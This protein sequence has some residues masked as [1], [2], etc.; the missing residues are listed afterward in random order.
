LFHGVSHDARRSLDVAT[1]SRAD[2]FVPQN[3][4]NRLIIDPQRV[5]VRR[6]ATPIGVPAFPYQVLRLEP[7]LYHTLGEVMQIERTANCVGK[8]PAVGRLD[9]IEKKAKRTNDRYCT[10]I[11][12]VFLSFGVFDDRPPD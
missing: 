6:K 12:F 7:R 2:V 10:W 11:L 8:E 9:L 4:L 1:L 3:R 5:Q